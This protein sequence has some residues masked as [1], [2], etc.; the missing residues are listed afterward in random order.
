MDKTGRLEVA[1]AERP[2][3]AL[4]VL[5]DRVHAGRVGRIP[6][7]D[8]ATTVSCGFEAM[9]RRVLVHAH[10]DPAPLLHGVKGGILRPGH[11]RSDEGREQGKR[12]VPHAVVT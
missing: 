12:R 7:Q 3:D 5:A 6:D 11:R 4:Q 8:D 1:G 9:E 10:R 2:R